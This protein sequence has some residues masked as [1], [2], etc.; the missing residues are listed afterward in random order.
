[1]SLHGERDRRADGPA[2]EDYPLQVGRKCAAWVLGHPSDFQEAAAWLRSLPDRASDP[3]VRQHYGP[4]LHRL[5]AAKEQL[6][7]HYQGAAEHVVDRMTNVEGH[8]IILYSALVLAPHFDASFIGL[9]WEW[10]RESGSV[11]D[12]RGLMKLG[13]EKIAL[14]NLASRCLMMAK[15]RIGPAS[16]RRDVA[17]H[18]A[19]DVDAAWESFRALQPVSPRSKSGQKSDESTSQAARAPETAM[20]KPN[21]SDS[22]FRPAT[23]FPKG[24]ADRLR[25]AA[26]KKRK[27]KRVRTKRIDGVVCYSVADARRWWPDDVPKNA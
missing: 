26:S 19:L 8:R 2:E 12:G 7:L 18:S 21:Y 15:D 16:R 13:T 27:T 22:E 20:L 9:S 1:M 5:G 25:Q 4:I 6:I 11:A 24:M 10:D 3:D 14:A 17:D 23:W